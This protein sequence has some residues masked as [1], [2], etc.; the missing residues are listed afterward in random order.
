MVDTAA[1]HRDGFVVLR[2]A[3]PRDTADAARDLLWQRL[4]LSPH[5][6]TAW[7]DPVRWTADLTGDG[8]F[9]DIVTSPALR[10]ALNTLC[11]PGGWRPRSALGNIPVRLPVRPAADDRGWHLDL[12]TPR[13][14]GSWALTGR[15]HTMLL[16]TLLSEVTDDDAPTRIRAGSH[17]DVA[18]HVGPGELDPDLVATCSAARP[19][20]Y[21]TG[22]PGDM[23]LLHPF[24]VHAADEH[25]GTVPRF[26]AQTPIELAEPLTPDSTTPL[27]RVFSATVR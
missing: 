18:E 5:D 26:M 20:H 22:S 10:G 19:V 3:A 11:G 13:A 25:R 8:P 2:H 17:R 7:T 21:A 1:F 9:H 16:L 15:P 6:P 4:G 27:A 23:Y 14:D 24:T 12:N